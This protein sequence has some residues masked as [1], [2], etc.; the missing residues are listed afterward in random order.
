M[1]QGFVDTRKKVPPLRY[2]NKPAQNTG[3]LCTISAIILCQIL[4]VFNE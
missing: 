3:I 1:S 2:Q 4:A